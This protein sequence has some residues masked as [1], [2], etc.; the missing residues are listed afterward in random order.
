MR[1]VANVEHPL[2]PIVGLG[3]LEHCTS[4]VSDSPPCVSFFDSATDKDMA[5]DFI[6]PGITDQMS[7]AIT[8]YLHS[9]MVNATICFADTPLLV[10]SAAVNGT[11]HCTWSVHMCPCI[12]YID[13]LIQC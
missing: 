6:D 1:K 8:S 13:R 10:W 9:V 2:F 7:K 11:G 3:A 4:L 5:I 12:L